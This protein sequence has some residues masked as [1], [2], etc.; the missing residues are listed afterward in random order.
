MKLNIDCIRDVLIQL[1]NAPLGHKVTIQ[2]LE[3]KLPQYQKHDIVYSCL[4]LEEESFIK[5][6][7]KTYFHDPIPVIHKIEDITM[8]GHGF[9]DTIREKTIWDK[10]KSS[11]KK[12]GIFSLNTLYELAIEVIKNSL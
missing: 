9:L 5:L 8:K 1:E 12:V 4:K 6:N 3:S 11:S 2:E 7:K 10:V